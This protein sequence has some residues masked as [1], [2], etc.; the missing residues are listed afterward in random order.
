[1]ET[2]QLTTDLFRAIFEK[3]SLK[4]NVYDNTYKT[5]SVFK[6][7]IKQLAKE[8]QESK[9]YKNSN[10]TFEYKNRGEFEVEL[11]FAGDILIFI[12]HTNVFEFSRDHEVMKLPYI[13]EDADRSYCGVINIYNFLGDSFKYKRINDLGYLIGRVF[14]NKD[15]H[16]FIEGKRELGQLYRRFD[17]ALMTEEAAHKLITSAVSYTLNFDL[18]TPPYEEVKLL[19]VQQI[20]TTLDNMKIRTGKRLGFKFQADKEEEEKAETDGGVIPK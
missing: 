11:K 20:Q 1:M 14:I 3:A 16:Y 6:S 18:L 2:D 13:K 10:I 9:L 15:N 7:V 4:Q 8:F 12:M 5:F 19:T 17:K